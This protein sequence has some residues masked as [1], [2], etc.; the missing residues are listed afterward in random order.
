[1][2]RT[3][4][5]MSAVM[6]VKP[7][8]SPVLSTRTYLDPIARG[9]STYAVPLA[10]ELKQTKQLE[11]TRLSCAKCTMIRGGLLERNAPDAVWKT[12]AGV[13]VR[14]DGEEMVDMIA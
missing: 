6:K 2:A 12:D 11:D 1:M 7:P 3:I 8:T 14:I 5:I 4:P 9:Q 10:D 13:V